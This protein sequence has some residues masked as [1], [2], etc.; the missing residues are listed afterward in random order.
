MNAPQEL[1][2]PAP[3]HP[4]IDHEA[5]HVWRADLNQEWELVRRLWTGLAPYEQKKANRFYLKSDRIHFIVARGALRD[6][7]SHYLDISPRNIE[8]SYGPF[9]K[10]DLLDRSAGNHLRF[11]VSHS[12]GIAVYAIARNREIGVDLELIREEAA[13]L[14][15]ADRFF[16]PL[17]V[18]ALR[19]IPRELQSVAFFNCWT[20]KEAYVKAR[21]E[22]IPYGLGRFTVSLAP[23]EPVAF[24]SSEERPEDMGNWLLMELPVVQGYASA[25]VVR[26]PVSGVNFW[27]WSP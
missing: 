18:L 25:L 11:N 15:I 10:P 26:R 27:R 6:I 23:G 3:E 4:V 24:R 5:V 22:G 17:E 8:F 12:N 9:G 20:H 1:W 2:H 19:E 13:S 16:S 14:D 7:L 21:G